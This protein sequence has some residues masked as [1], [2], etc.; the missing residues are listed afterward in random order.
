[1]KIVRRGASRSN[2]TNSS[3][4]K[5]PTASARSGPAA[6]GQDAAAAKAAPHT[7]PEGE[8]HS[9]AS[10]SSTPPAPVDPCTEIRDMEIETAAVVLGASENAAPGA[11][12]EEPETSEE[13]PSSTTDDE[14]PARQTTA[15][16][17][18]PPEPEQEAGAHVMADET[19]LRAQITEENFESTV[20]TNGEEPSVSGKTLT[21]QDNEQ[22]TAAGGPTPPEQ[23]PDAHSAADETHPHTQCKGKAAGE[24]V[25]RNKPG[26]AQAK[27]GQARTSDGTETRAMRQKRLQGE[28]TA[29][30]AASHSARCV[31]HAG[32]AEAGPEESW[33][34]TRQAKGAE[35]TEAQTPAPPAL[36]NPS[37]EVRVTAPAS[38]DEL[39]KTQAAHKATAAPEE[40]PFSLTAPPETSDEQ[41]AQ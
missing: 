7:Q 37:R 38:S 41:S 17:P 40:P 39:R 31:G 18:T 16:D 3:T 26:N 22:Q 36:V 27:L 35:E 30:E 11:T 23:E 5:D 21:T 10:N 19:D 32:W 34:A 20:G 24:N 29:K 33:D 12:R 9:D 2:T 8:T 13:A 6:E 25:R 15:R 28:Q 4:N 1:V 14:R